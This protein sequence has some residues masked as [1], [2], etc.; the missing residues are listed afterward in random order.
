MHSTQTNVVLGSRPNAG[1][2]DVRKGIRSLMLVPELKSS[3]RHPP[4]PKELGETE[5]KSSVKFM[6]GR[7]CCLNTVIL[8]A[9]DEMYSLCTITLYACFFIKKFLWPS[10]DT[11]STFSRFHY[12]YFL[13]TLL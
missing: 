5:V 7:F 13:K 12:Q 10:T 11:F 1:H 2:G 6:S 3:Q 4:S 8:C 9:N